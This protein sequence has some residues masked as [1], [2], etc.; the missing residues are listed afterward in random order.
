MSSLT[1]DQIPQFIEHSNEQSIS[2][3]ILH[4]TNPRYVD[5]LEKK[6]NRKKRLFP[7]MTL[8]LKQLLQIL[9]YKPSLK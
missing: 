9:F 2:V 4:V 1:L 6:S 5:F 8:N 3:V 7:D